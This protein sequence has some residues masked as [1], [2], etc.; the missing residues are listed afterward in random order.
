MP[1]SSVLLLALVV[2]ALMCGLHARIDVYG[3]FVRGAREGLGTLLDMLPYLCAM[4]MATALLRE[5]GVLALLEQWAAPLLAAMGLPQEIASVAI[6]R[7]LSGSAA[8]AAVR[9]VLQSVGADS[10]A[11]RIAC[12]LCGASETVFF[13]CAL[14]LGA[15]GAR[16]AGCALLIALSAYLAGLLAAGWAV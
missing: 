14:Y 6:L 3:A 7:P 10:R 11:G 4:L 1:D 2:F 12:V 15:A 9:D 16:R 13:T 8:T 5:T